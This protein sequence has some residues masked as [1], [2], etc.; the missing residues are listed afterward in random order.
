MLVGH[1]ATRRHEGTGPGADKAGGVRR[2]QNNLIFSHETW[3]KSCVSFRN[4][5]RRFKLGADFAGFSRE[6]V[7]LAGM[8]AAEGVALAPVQVQKLFF[9]IDKKIA[10]L[11]GGPHFDFQPYSYGPFDHAVYG[12]I[13]RLER[14]NFAEA[15]S[16]ASRYRLY[17]LTP[18]GQERGAEILAAMPQKAADYIR[19]VSQFVRERS[20]AQLVSAIYDAYP[21]MREN[22]VFVEK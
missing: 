13:E 18:A 4:L 9:L 19:R 8:A 11:I 16:Q 17:S 10:D 21:E 22:S 5:Q 1:Q 15:I 20:F 2:R 6:D 12:V 7:V 3:L 14:E